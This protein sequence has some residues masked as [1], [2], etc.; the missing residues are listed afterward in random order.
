MKKRAEMTVQEWM[1]GYIG[2]GATDF[3]TGYVAGIESGDEFMFGL[4]FDF[5]SIG[6]FLEDAR[7]HATATGYVQSDSIGGK[8]RVEKAD[9]QLFVGEEDSRCRYMWYRLFF[10][11]P[12]KG[13]LTMLG[14]K[15]LYNDRALDM[16]PDITTLYLKILEGHVPEGDEEGATAIA[17]GIARVRTKDFFRTMMSF[18][19]PEVS[20]ASPRSLARFG[21]LFVQEVWGIYG[22]RQERE[23]FE[24]ASDGLR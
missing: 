6:T 15:V 19:F 10:T 4:K 11:S 7:H 24:V 21:G 12:S 3:L 23:R 13:P 22:G 16:W 14:F 9:I 8:L 18:R 17:M 2:V 5:P 1:K 20:L